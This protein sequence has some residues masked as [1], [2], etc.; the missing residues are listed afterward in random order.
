M[1]TWASRPRRETGAGA[2]HIPGGDRGMLRETSTAWC[3]APPGAQPV[4]CCHHSGSCLVRSQQQWPR[5]V[6]PTGCLCNTHPVR[7]LQPHP[8][9][10][11]R[12]QV[13]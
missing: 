4:G 7:S 6:T 13:G 11:G 12:G 9:D 1:R 5:M 10:L 2:T 3:L 8:W